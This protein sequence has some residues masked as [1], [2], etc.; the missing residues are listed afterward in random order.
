MAA[1]TV[2]RVDA[3]TVVALMLATP[4]AGAVR[5]ADIDASPAIDGAVP[6]LRVT[7]VEANAWGVEP[8]AAPRARVLCAR[9]APSERVRAL[10]V[11]D[12]VEEVAVSPAD[13]EHGAAV[14]T[15]WVVVVDAGA[16]IAPRWADV[17]TAAAAWAD[18]VPRPGDRLAVVFLGETRPVTRSPW[19]TFEERGRALEALG[20]QALPLMPLGRDEPLG[21]AFRAAVAEAAEHLPTLP[22][23]VD[24]G[25]VVAGLFTD[26]R[27]A[28]AQQA[29]EVRGDRARS[30]HV[31][32]TRL[33]DVEAFWFP[34]DAANPRA[35]GSG[36]VLDVA[37]E[38]GRVHRLDGA[39]RESVV[40]ALALEARAPSEHA[41]RVRL[42]LR[43]RDLLP[44]VPAVELVG[45]GAAVLDRSPAWTLPFGPEAWPLPVPSV[46]AGD[47]PDLFLAPPLGGA[48]PRRW[49][50]FWLPKTDDRIV[51]EPGKPML[52][53]HLE[54]LVATDHE[55][56]TSTA[57]GRIGAT[58][59]AA[60]LVARASAPLSLVV[61]DEVSH[62][63]TPLRHDRAPELARGTWAVPL[64][65][66]PRVLRLAVL[67]VGLAA[68]AF[69]A[70]SRRRRSADG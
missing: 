42:D 17:R 58:L 54:A 34:H 65:D 67:L 38:R 24:V 52:R 22:T 33:V 1:R 55:L 6:E 7:L 32:R 69:A 30:P 50:V 66:G 70:R 11:V 51:V 28:T 8:C 48:S 56:P 21:P 49:R 29:L 46:D 15:A 19:F 9:A 36:G 18:A 40:R 31:S 39:T 41:A 13:F 47:L 61:F 59:D 64:V 26:G 23:S 35:D 4:V 20:F 2:P 5:I 16:P 10:R 44:S 14:A 68:L 60:A 45:E 12:G 27:T 63:A 37:G 62:R 3:V 43:D 53:T 57:S 25:R